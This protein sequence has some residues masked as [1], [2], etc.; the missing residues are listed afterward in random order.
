MAPNSITISKSRPPLLQGLL[1]RYG[2]WAE[3]TVTRHGVVYRFDFPAGEDPCLLLAPRRGSVQLISD[4]AIEGSQDLHGATGYF[5]LRFDRPVSSHAQL[6]SG[7]RLQFTGVAPIEVR[8]GVS[9]IGVA[10]ARQ[11]RDKELGDRPFDQLVE[12]ARQEWQTALSQIRVEGGSDRQRRTLYTALYR[13][14]GRMHNVTEE[15]RYFSGYDGQVH[16]GEPDFYVGDQIWDTFRSAHPLRALIDPQ[17]ELDMVRSYV[18][19][20]AQSGWLPRFPGIGGDVPTMLGHHTVAAIVDAY[21]K[22]LTDFDVPQ[23]YAAMR[24]RLTEATSLPWRNGPLTELDHV[25]ADKASSR[26]CD[27]ERTR[28]CRRSIPSKGD[29]QSPSPSNAAMTPTPWP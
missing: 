25:Y 4:T 26:H 2:I 29:R 9:F 18:R 14:M 24:K 17:R 27:R 12:E 28:P 5:S 10:Q 22:G 7:I 20:A 11:N 3:F 19:M 15:G 23:A 1:E 6:E 21:R 13:M 8:I 16:S